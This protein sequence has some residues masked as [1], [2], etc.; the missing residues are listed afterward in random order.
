ML[1]KITC[2]AAKVAPRAICGDPTSIGILAVLG[3]AAL[4]A[5]VADKCKSITN[6]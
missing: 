6:N 4:V 3:A 1:T 5:V 2:Y